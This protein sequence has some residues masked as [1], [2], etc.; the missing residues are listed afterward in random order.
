[1][2]ARLSVRR[3]FGTALTIIVHQPLI[4]VPAVIVATGVPLAIDILLAH[5]L[6]DAPAALLTT[7]VDNLATVIFAGA[8]EELVHRW[9]EGQRRIR[10]LGVLSRV[11]PAIVP[12]LAAGFL[13]ALGIALAFLL[14]IIP[15][16][17]LY[18]RWAVVGPVVVAERPGIRRS[19]GRSRELGRG[20]YWRI[21]IVIV[22]LEVL[23]VLAG[24]ASSGVSD[25]VGD[26][27][28]EPIALAIGEA[29]ILPIE[30]VSIP[31]MY[32]RLREREDAMSDGLEDA[33]A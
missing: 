30:A 3:V 18:A 1:M 10:M 26:P 5:Y 24:A 28:D 21:L 29:I 12:L 9:E 19:F 22:L 25:M 16:L 7:L 13:Q 17:L 20:S 27:P 11:P 32:W 15:G 14:L 31:V 8:A 33:A 2:P 6:S 23:T 4:I